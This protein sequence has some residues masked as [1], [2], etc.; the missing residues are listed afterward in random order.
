MGRLAVDSPGPDCPNQGCWECHQRV[1]SNV[2]LRQTDGAKRRRTVCLRGTPKSDSLRLAQNKKAP[3]VQP[4]VE[5][6]KKMGLGPILGEG[7]LHPAIPHSAPAPLMS[8]RLDTELGEI[9]MKL[10][11]DLAPQTCQYISKLVTDGLYNGVSLRENL[12]C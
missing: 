10:R 2:F 5:N 12:W 4:P 1:M 8:I 11:P 3:K 7:S 6:T 9:V